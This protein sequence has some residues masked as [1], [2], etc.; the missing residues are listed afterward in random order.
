MK[1]AKADDTTSGIRTETQREDIRIERDITEPTRIKRI[2]REGEKGKPC[3][4]H[5][6]A[7]QGSTTEVK[8]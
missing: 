5:M 1:L 7:A 3:L 8:Y 6:V 4:G 2:Y